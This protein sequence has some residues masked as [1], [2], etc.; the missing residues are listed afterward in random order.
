MTRSAVEPAHR[1]DEC[2]RATGAVVDHVARCRAAHVE[3]MRQ[4]DS[5]VV[6]PD[7]AIDGEHVLDEGREADDVRNAVQTTELGVRSVDDLARAVGVGDV[8]DD[9][10]TVHLLGDVRGAVA[11]DIG[12][13]DPCA[14]FGEEERRLA[15]DPVAASHHQGCLAFQPEPVDQRHRRHPPCTVV[16]THRAHTA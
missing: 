15:S 12:D 3:V 1:R 8:A 13:R 6:F 16:A 9:R 10:D 5:E 11:V 7:V 2:Q 4:V 14:R